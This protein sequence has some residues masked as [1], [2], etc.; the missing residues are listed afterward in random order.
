MNFITELQIVTLVERII[1]IGFRLERDNGRKRHELDVIFI[2]YRNDMTG[3]G[4]RKQKFRDNDL[5][6]ELGLFNEALGVFS[7]SHIYTYTPSSVHQ[8]GIPT[9]FYILT[10]KAEAGQF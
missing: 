6:I 8:C 4:K 3:V 9:L 5:Y 1:I 2:G 10:F 7:Y